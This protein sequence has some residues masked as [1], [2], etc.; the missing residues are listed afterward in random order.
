MKTWIVKLLGLSS[1]VWNFF[2]S[3]LREVVASGVEEL[4]PLALEIV[5]SMAKTDLT[6]AEK[7]DGAVGWLKSQAVDLGIDA[8]VS[9]L[10]FAVESAVQRLKA[11]GGR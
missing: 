8:G 10:R 3:V 2:W 6:E 5:R 1:A 4:L 7:F 9:V 11:E